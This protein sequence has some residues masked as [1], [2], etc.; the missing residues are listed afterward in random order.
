MG[1]NWVGGF[2]FVSFES[3]LGFFRLRFIIDNHHFLGIFKTHQLFDMVL[4]GFNC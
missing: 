1:D 4:K 2:V 3:F